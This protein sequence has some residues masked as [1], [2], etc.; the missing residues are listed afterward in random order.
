M[1]LTS[2]DDES[3]DVPVAHPTGTMRAIVQ[4]RYG[5][6]PEDVLRLSSTAVPSTAP[7]QVLVRVHAASVDRGTWHVMAGLPYP[8]RA[9]GFGLTRPRYVN[10]GRSL[11]GTVEVVGE[12]VA[13][14]APGDEVFGVGEATFA[15]YA[16]ARPDRLSRK[17]AALSFEQAAAVPVSGLTALQAVR[18]HARVAAGEAV[19]VLGASGGVGTFAVQIAKASGATVTGVCSTGKLDLVAALGAD[20][21]VDHTREDA[22]AGGRRFD[23][24]LDTGGNT[25]L[26]HLRRAMTAR[27]R[28]VVV[29][30]ETD[31]RLLGGSGRQ[32]RA[33]LLNP[34]VRQQL[35]TFIASENAEDLA[36]LAAL[37]EAGALTP[38][39]DR[40]YPLAQTAA[41]L[42]RLLQGQA[43][44]KIVISLG[45]DSSTTGSTS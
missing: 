12:Q 39:V 2:R 36:A 44:G 40:T 4:D 6:A 33:Q 19:L 20:H 41:A 45:P 31:G 3:L 26:A 28:L 8:I 14:L 42:R 15:P 27:G 11:A 7:D 18:D 23:V 38:A 32:L 24:V 34:F 35:G 43:R 25:R 29:G 16:V 17:P 5:P 22:T 1:K 37:V 21:V 9:A 13:G 10:P 30:G